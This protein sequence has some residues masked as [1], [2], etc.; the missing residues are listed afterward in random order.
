MDSF[1]F[2]RLTLEKEDLDLCC[3][4]FDYSLVERAL[5]T[6]VRSFLARASPVATPH[7]LRDSGLDARR[8]KIGLSTSLGPSSCST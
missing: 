8:E 2:P 1:S 3:V 6:L 5:P 7:Y 4:E